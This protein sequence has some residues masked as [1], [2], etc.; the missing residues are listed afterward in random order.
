MASFRRFLLRL[1]NFLRPGRAERELT[2]ELISHLTL[3]E[4]QFQRRGMTPEEARLAARRATG[5]VEQ[6]KELHRDARS[7]IS[8]EDSRR[9]LKYSVRTLVKNPGFT[10]TAVVTLALAIGANSAI[11]SA[12]YAILLKPLPIHSPAD[13]VVCWGADSSR[14]LTVVELSYR[15]FQDWAAGSRSF[16][17]AAAMGSSNWTMVLEGHGEPVRLSYTGVTASFFETVGVRPFL[18]RTFRPEDDVPNAPRVMV[19]NYGAWIRRFGAN[20]DVVGTTIRLNEQPHTVVGVM[21]RGF[22]FPRGAEFWMPVVPE[23]AASSARWKSDALTNVGALF[24]IGRLREGVTP[25]VASQELDQLATRL[26]ATT[27]TPRFGSSVVVT[28]FLDYLLGPT[29]TALWLLFAA[30]GVLLLIACANVSGLMLTR[31]SLRRRE[32]AIRLALGATRIGVGRLWILEIVVVSVTGGVLGL[33]ASRCIAA[34]IIALGPDDVPRVADISINVPVGAFTFAAVLVT[35]LLC[36]IGPVRQ[37]CGSN[38]LDV[39]ADAARGTPGKQS[40][41]T[42]SLLLTIQVA[43]AVMLLVSA[44]LVVRSFVKLRAIDLGFVASHV[45]TMNVAPRDARPSANEWFDELLRRI[46]TLPEVEA[47]GA[48]YLPPLAV[49]PI[50]QETWV[51]LD[52]QPVTPE[53]GGRNPMLNYQVATPRYFGAMGVALKRGRLFDIHDVRRSPRVVILGESAA[54]RL[55]PGENPIGQRLIIPTFTPGE[56]QNAWRTVVGVVAD[57]RYR[58]INDV[59]LD[60][61]DPALQASSPADNLVV[62][63]AGDPLTVVGAVQAKARE[64]DPHVVIDRVTTMDSVVSRAIAPWRLSAWMLTLFAALASVLA[65]VGLFSLVSL[66]VASRRHEFAVRLALGAAPRHIMRVVM[67]VASKWVS[68]GV[69]L[70]LIAAIGSSRALGSLLFE[71]DTLDGATYA[72]VIAFVVSLVTLA[73]YLPARRAARIDPMAL[74]RCD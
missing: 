60:V 50:G 39:L 25:A 24:V 68:A 54:R 15:N 71:V 10:C 1:Y 31:V 52:G 49:G 17:H 69:A 8:L 37:A 40:R 46:A 14:N 62:R 20:P 67:G 70:G 29:R 22:D 48:I 16:T 5:G 19:L 7:F 42:R 3:L 41:R 18:G 56:M 34:L 36:G 74:L 65:S 27:T 6:A 72:A 12:V 23:L 53:A 45:L 59:R 47:A 21:P 63:T 26:Q 2:R 64:L 43:L 11:F 13:L 57:V 33:L 51:I 66:D 32:H 28:P 61:Y 44:G 35:A 38:L 73:S 58:G 30:V 4:D 9:D 55:W